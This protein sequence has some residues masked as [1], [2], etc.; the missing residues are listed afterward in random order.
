MFQFSSYFFLTALIFIFVP[1]E[2]LLAVEGVDFMHMRYATL[3]CGNSNPF[4]SF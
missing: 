1:I 4:G 3:V 2:L